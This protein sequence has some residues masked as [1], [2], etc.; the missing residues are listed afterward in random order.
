MVDSFYYRIPW[1]LIVRKL[2]T[3]RTDMLNDKPYP[4]LIWARTGPWS[5]GRKQVDTPS[6][7]LPETGP[8]VMT[9]TATFW[10]S[11]PVW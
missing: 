10:Y 11:L 3:C 4:R 9:E 7:S 2:Y 8:L 6:W 5:L 1:L